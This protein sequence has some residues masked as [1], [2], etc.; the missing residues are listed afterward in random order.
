MPVARCPL[1]YE[2]Q[3]VEANVPVHLQSWCKW[4]V[5]ASVLLLQVADAARSRNDSQECDRVP[6]QREP[7][8][9]VLSVHSYDL[10]YL[11]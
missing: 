10:K 8:G 11:R 1:L 6:H 9:G 7:S 5:K 2:V 3:H 4:V